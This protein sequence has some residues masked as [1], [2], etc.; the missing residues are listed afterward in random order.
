MYACEQCLAHE[1]ASA[2]GHLKVCN[3]VCRCL[4]K[5]RRAAVKCNFHNIMQYKCN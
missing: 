4:A 1:Q 2:L 3:C 5:M